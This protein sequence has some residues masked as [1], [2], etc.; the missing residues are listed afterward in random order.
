MSLQEL[1]A[2]FPIYLEKPN[3]LWKGWYLEEEKRLLPFLPASSI[4][5]I[6]HI[7]STA[8][9]TI[10]AKPIV[11]IL[12][13]TVSSNDFPIVERILMGHG[14]RAIRRG[15]HSVD[16]NRGYTKKGFAEKVYH[17]HLRVQGDNKELYFRDYLISHLEIAKEYE[18]LKLNLWKRYEHDRDGYTEAKG[19]FVNKT[20]ALALKAYPGK[21]D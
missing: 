19:P 20:T 1:W 6:S 4:K 11:D 18:S 21:Y 13:E 5:R 9:G 3:P 8:I 7:G 14:Y 15:V 12:L 2:L 10:W 17:L 16:F